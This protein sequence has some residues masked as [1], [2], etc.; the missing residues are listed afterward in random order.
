MLNI[1]KENL[2]NSYKNI[3]SPTKNITIQPK[4]FGIVVR[5]WKNNIYVY[6]KNTLSLIPEAS[7]LTIKLIKGYFNLYNSKLEKRIRKIK[8]NLKK[9]RLS[10]NKIFISQGQ[11]K[12]TNDLINITIYFYNR[13][14]KD[15]KRIIWKRCIKL[16]KKFP[17]NKK[18]L[19]FKNATLRL[20]K[21]RIKQ[22]KILIDLFK[23]INQKKII[24]TLQKKSH[25]IHIRKFLRKAF[26]Y[27]YLKQIIFI[28]KSKFNS[29][30]LQNLINLVKKIYKKNIQFNFIN[31]KYFFLIVIF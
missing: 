24:Q 27:L 31:V 5:N 12:H 10:I 4:K 7:R 11:F 21:Y 1:I 17:L 6:N 25:K 14:L 18:L 2:K 30:Y 3:T 19:I 16:F 26:I 15:Y 20:I 13:Q 8:I 28:N 9:R 22:K 29:Y 23:E